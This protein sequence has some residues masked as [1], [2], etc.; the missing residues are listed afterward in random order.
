MDWKDQ[1]YIF[2]LL[3]KNIASKKNTNTSAISEKNFLKILAAKL[4][5]K[6]NTKK[7]AWFILMTQLDIKK[8]EIY[9]QA[10]SETWAV[11]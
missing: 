10:I 9:N 4:I 3:I 1:T 8:F 11:Q 2:I 7:K 5:F 6:T